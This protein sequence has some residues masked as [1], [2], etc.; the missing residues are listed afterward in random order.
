MPTMYMHT[1]GCRAQK[2]P[3]V[4][5]ARA[6]NLLLDFDFL[7]YILMSMRQCLPR[8]SPS[9]PWP[10][11]TYVYAQIHAEVYMYMPIDT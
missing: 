11:A 2:K 5:N 3:G 8:L 10:A 9:M 6:F 1:G 7:S 4:N